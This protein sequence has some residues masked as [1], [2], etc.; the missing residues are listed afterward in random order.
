MLVDIGHSVYVEQFEEHFLAAASDFYRTEATELIT[1]CD[2]P[3][4]IRR[5]ERRL[6]E[7]Q[8]RVKHYLDASTDAKI[9][10]RVET[11]LVANQMKV[12]P[13]ALPLR[14]CSCS[15]PLP[16][17][18]LADQGGLAICCPTGWQ[19]S[20]AIDLEARLLC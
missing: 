9:T 16:T 18:R 7:E 20:C 4:Y 5:A 12:S 13:P 10:H 11:E 1:S 15:P 14:P 6:T 3:E 19:R 8:E 2:C 17:R